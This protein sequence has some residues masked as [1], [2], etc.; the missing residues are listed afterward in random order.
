M[1]NI[2][3]L[4]KRAYMI[5]IMFTW[6]ESFILQTFSVSSRHNPNLQLEMKLMYLLLLLLIISLTECRNEQEAKNLIDRAEIL[7]DTNPDSAYLLLDSILIP[8]NLNDEL[9]ARWCMLYG[10]VADILYTEM[11]YVQQLSRAQSYYQSQ[12]NVKEQARIGLY[13][14]RSYVEDKEYEKAMRA[15][16][17]AL[18]TAIDAEDYD[19][20]GNIYN[21][22]G[23]LYA[24]DEQYLLAK[25]KYKEA[26]EYYKIAKNEYNYAFALRDMAHMYILADSS[27]RAKPYLQEASKIISLKGD[28]T[29]R[30]AI[31][32]SLGAM[33]SRLGENSSAKK[34]LQ[35]AIGL[36][37]SKDIP[38]YSELIEIYVEEKK[39]TEAHDCLRAVKQIIGD[40][41]I[42]PDILYN[43]YKV[44]KA[45]GRVDRALQYLEKY[46]TVADSI[47][48]SHDEMN[49]HKVEK[50][51]D[52]LKISL[53]NVNLHVEKQR[54]FILLLLSVFIGLCIFLIY[55]MKLNRSNKKI[56][57]QRMD[58]DRKNIVLSG[59]QDSLKIK[60]DELNDLSSKLSENEIFISRIG[61]RQILEELYNQ[62]NQEL[63]SL[64]NKIYTHQRELLMSSSIA[65]KVMKLSSKVIAGADKSPLSEKDWKLIIAKVN[66]IYPALELKLIDAG[67]SGSELRYCY[68]SIFGLDTNSEAILLHIMPDSVNKRRQRV[69][70]RLGISGENV[71]L[72]TFLTKGD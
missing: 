56:Y 59:L 61:S 35:E 20:V 31:A 54:F 36:S 57:N 50:Q 23:N 18:K 5:R 7:M 4:Y 70:L 60:Q 21:Y 55:Q 6:N 25:N 15:Y 34:Y 22:I 17:A 51:Y 40:N 1:A 13:L 29:D 42:P 69:R 28:S 45:E 44:E 10:K 68:L 16:L 38:A 53:E 24:L 66:E 41:T 64:K 12:G 48:I 46:H 14:G 19:E 67:V 27:L 9:L 39:F 63:D 71:D 33:Y 58:I 37:K 2:Q 26:A 65:K 72:L 8:D 49:L 43:F 30:A 11:P 3:N 52:F 62:K 47:H 32:Y